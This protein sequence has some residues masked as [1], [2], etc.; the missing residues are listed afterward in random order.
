MINNILK[1]KKGLF[2]VSIEGGVALD[3]NM[4]L[5]LKV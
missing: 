2:R 3:L 4:Y 5:Q 1:K